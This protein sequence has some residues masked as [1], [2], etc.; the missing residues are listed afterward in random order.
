VQNQRAVVAKGRGMSGGQLQAIDSG[1]LTGPVARGRSS[2]VSLV[3]GLT[4]SWPLDSVA[5]R[6]STRVFPAGWSVQ[7]PGRGSIFVR[8]SDESNGL[9]PVVLL[10][11]LAATA[12]LN[13]STTM[14]ALSRSFS[15]VAP[16]LRGHGSS[17][18]ER[19]RFTVEE[20]ADDVAALADVLSLGRFIV[21]G[22]SLGGAIAQVLCRRHPDRVRGL[23]LCATSRSFRGTLLER[24]LFTA[25]RPLRVASRSIPDRTARAAG[26]F[27]ADR[28][29]GNHSVRGLADQ[30]G[31]FEVRQVLD[32]ALALANYRS[33]DWIGAI[34]VPSAV[35]VH[36]RDWLVPA[37][38]QFALA[39]SLPGALVYQVDGD[40]FAVV[41]E[42]EAFA[43]TLITAVRDVH[44]RSRRGNS[45]ALHAVQAV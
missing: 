10:H 12:D 32:A 14:P 35:L 11:G 13:W 33:H 23:V 27:L 45:S 39:H 9:P 31:K 16:D 40:H 26:R 7:V 38:R 18:T 3:G 1:S 5:T 4:P 29:V 28:F 6:D 34:D 42:P 36:L 43:S 22:Y 19:D 25:L 44:Y 24:V 20:A 37:R 41:K 21:V 30:V 17:T 2:H 8:V 15:V